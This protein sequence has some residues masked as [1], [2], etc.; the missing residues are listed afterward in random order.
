MV[1]NKTQQF[2][3]ISQIQKGPQIG[4]GGQLRLK[5]VTLNALQTDR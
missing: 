4:D 2:L 3:T 5:P 1:L